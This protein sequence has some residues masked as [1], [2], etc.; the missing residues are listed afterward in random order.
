MKRMILVC[1]MILALCLLCLPA[2]A[3]ETFAPQGEYRVFCADGLYGVQTLDGETVIPARFTGIQPICGDLCVVEG[4]CEDENAEGLWRVST[5][6]EL[7]PCE[8]YGISVTGTL[9]MTSDP[10]SHADGYCFTRLFDPDAGAFVF[11]VSGT[12]YDGI[13]E[14]PGEPLFELYQIGW[15]D[16]LYAL[17]APDGTFLADAYVI[18]AEAAPGSHGIVGIAAGEW[19]DEFRYLNTATGTWLEGTWRSGFAFVDGYAA[20]WGEDWKWYVIDETGAVVSPAY[21]WI[22]NERNAVPYA[23]G[24]FTVRQDGGWYVIRVSPDAEPEVLLGPVQ[25][26]GDPDHLGNGIFALRTPDGDTLLFSGSDGRERTLEHT[27]AGAAFVADCAL[28][29]RDREEGFLFSD[30]SVIEPAYEVCVEFIGAY[31]FVMLDGLWYAI[32]RS[33]QVDM[34]AAYQGAALAE[35]ETGFIV[36]LDDGTLLYLDRDLRPVSASRF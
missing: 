18:E 24:L 3:E 12:E 5:G 1:V 20:V 36:E 29:H 13:W 34:S 10:C 28:I 31:G 11:D 33:G 16:G 32:D 9:V 4:L 19:G 23:Q 26:V 25:C 2:M 21:D 27:S 7:L 30:F 8:Y 17:I 6:E 14:V 22:G 35:D 15:D